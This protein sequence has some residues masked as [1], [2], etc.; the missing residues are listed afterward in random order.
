[1][2]WWSL[3]AGLV[4]LALAGY[5]AVTTVVSTATGG[6]PITSRIGRWCWRAAHR[7][8]QRPT[9]PVLTGAG[10]AIL[11]LSVATWLML[12]WIGWTLVFSADPSAVVAAT[13]GEPADWS[14][15]A[16]FAGFTAFTLGIGDYVPAGA[17][18]QLVTVVASISGL[19]LA[20]AA[21]TYLVPVVTAVT[22][23]SRLAAM[24]AGYGGDAH[25]FVCEFYDDASVAYLQQ[26]LPQFTTSLLLTAERHLAYPILHYFHPRARD[27]DLRVQ[28]TSLDDA[29][30]LVEYGLADEVVRPH[31][32]ALSAVRAAIEQL[33]ERSDT[34]ER[35]APPLVLLPLAQAGIATVDEDTFQRRLDALGAHRRRVAGYATESKW[36][37]D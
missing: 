11:L 1:M 27:V 26:V 25:E 3:A 36:P 14:Q 8:G 33:L 12:L 34:S 19:A 35:P 18:W 2:T 15:R 17:P 22:E 30:T 9:S 24:I 32:A 4:V 37:L 20:T 29:I 21:I 13:T 28:L 31:P 6:G 5:D 7:L 10:P 23:R 16:Y